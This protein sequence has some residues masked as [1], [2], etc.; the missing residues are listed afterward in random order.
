MAQA[1]DAGLLRATWDE[2]IGRGITIYREGEE[3][4]VPDAIAIEQSG[5]L[6][7]WI[8]ASCGEQNERWYVS[9]AGAEIAGSEHF[10]EM[11]PYRDAGVST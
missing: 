1:E 7:R 4:A 10:H 8:C 5:S 3:P 6:F 2:L 9:P 11:H